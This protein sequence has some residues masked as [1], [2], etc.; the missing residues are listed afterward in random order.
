MRIKSFLLLVAVCV[1][2]LTASE[3]CSAAL[4][5]YIDSDG[6]VNIADDLQSIPEQFRSSAVIVNGQAEE[7]KPAGPVPQE[8]TTTA[9]GTAPGI[10]AVSGAVPRA[11]EAAAGETP[12]APIGKRAVVSL[13]VV[14]TAVFGFLMLGNL[15]ADHLKAVRAA[16]MMILWAASVYLIYA[17]AGDLIRVIGTVGDTVDAA[18]Q[19]SAEKGRKAAKAAKAL[20]ALLEGA[21]NVPGEPGEA[22]PEQKE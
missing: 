15:Q 21:G 12:S 11:G 4:F 19:Q 1:S 3:N 18:Q 20:N 10:G 5:K 7:P 13:I 6:T 8:Q 16:R 14:V 2:C 9:P 17:H 22:G